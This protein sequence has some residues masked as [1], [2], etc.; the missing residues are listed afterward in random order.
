MVKKQ[1]TIVRRI[2]VSLL[3]EADGSIVGICSVGEEKTKGNKSNGTGVIPNRDQRLHTVEVPE[4][5][6]WLLERP[7]HFLRWVKDNLL[8]KKRPTST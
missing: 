7:D 2:P 5:A 1:K 6:L 8:D 3:C 4:E